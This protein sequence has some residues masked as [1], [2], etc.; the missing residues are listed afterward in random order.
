MD[1]KPRKA[2]RIVVPSYYLGNSKALRIYWD[3][4][5]NE[6]KTITKKKIHIDIDEK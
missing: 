6:T 4:H 5:W 3:L 1:D 2:R